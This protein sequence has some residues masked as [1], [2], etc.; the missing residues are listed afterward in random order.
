[1]RKVLTTILILM[2]LVTNL[3]STALAK[4]NDE[5]YLKYHFEAL[6]QNPDSIYWE[7]IFSNKNDGIGYPY[8]LSE[9]SK[10]DAILDI[11]DSKKEAILKKYK[12]SY[13]DAFNK[14]GKNAEFIALADY[15]FKNNYSK[16]VNAITAYIKPHEQV[17]I[18]AISNGLKFSAKS[19]LELFKGIRAIV[20]QDTGYLKDLIV[21]Y[22]IDKG[23]S[24]SND[25]LVSIVVDTIDK[26]VEYA[27]EAL[28]KGASKAT[29]KKINSEIKKKMKKVISLPD[30]EEML[31]ELFP[32]TLEDAKLRSH[33]FMKSKRQTIKKGTVDSIDIV[34]DGKKL[35]GNIL[36]YVVD[37]DIVKINKTDNGATVQGLKKGSTKVKV[38]MFGMP[39]EYEFTIRVK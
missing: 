13:K 29:V 19:S 10:A 26:S 28:K 20:K 3:T 8:N 5:D 21:D 17:V 1:M 23:F 4:K 35:R 25:E 12:K 6:L 22:L 39:S 33:D 24:G 16:F 15:S 34:L 9:I 14:H 27:E 36:Y 2:L 31:E 18:N 30:L 7:Y 37:L 11:K 38:F 32:T